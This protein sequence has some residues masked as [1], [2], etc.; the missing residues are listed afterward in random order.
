MS[1]SRH[2]LD[3]LLSES[4]GELRVFGGYSG[5]GPGQ[6]ENELEVGGWLLTQARPEHVFGD[7]DS[8]YKSLCEQV[9]HAILFGESTMGNRPVDPGL[10]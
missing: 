4:Q 8:L 1:M 5:W 2:H 3:E 10:N 6:L 9:G 7:T